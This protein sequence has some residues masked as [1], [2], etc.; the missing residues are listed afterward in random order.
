MPPSRKPNLPPSRKLNF[1][2]QLDST[3]IE[4][5]HIPLFASWID[6]KKSSHYNRRNIPYDFKLLY[7]SSRDGNDVGSFHRNCDNKGATIFIAKIKDS[8]HL[9]G[10]YN[11][12]DWSGG[13]WKTATESFMFSFT[14][15]KDISTA[16]FG[17]SNNGR[18]SV[19][20][21]S[22]YGPTMGKLRSSNN[23]WTYDVG[24]H[25]GNLY[26][27]IEVPARFTVE[28]YEVFQVTK[29]QI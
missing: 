18:Q 28:D 20:C 22:D 3:L 14:N 8:M 7:R 25:V 23:N 11:P 21:Y 6:K 12:L 15:G 1:K 24:G 19:F 16:K 29:K 9:I 2:F 5:N 4:P 10:G 27:N 26:P 13:G 17:Y